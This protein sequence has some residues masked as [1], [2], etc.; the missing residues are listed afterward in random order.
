M[1]GLCVMVRRQLR[2]NR[3]VLIVLT[4]LVTINDIVQVTSYQSVFPDPSTRAAALAS[5]T[6]NGALRA[7]YG[8][9]Y[10]ITDPTG[11]PAWRSIGFMV[12]VMAMWAA[13]ITVGALRREEEAGR[14]ELALSQPQSR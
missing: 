6:S 2:V 3:T 5:F 9:P 4:A 1:N 13:F 14:G 7:F 10:D 11:W 8:Y 12:V